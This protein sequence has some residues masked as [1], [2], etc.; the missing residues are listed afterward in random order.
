MSS[1]A[2]SSLTTETTQTHTDR[3]TLTEEDICEDCNDSRGTLYYCIP[4]SRTLCERCWNNTPPHGETS[5][6]RF[7][8]FTAVKHEK[9]ELAVLKAVQPAFFLPSDEATLQSMLDEDEQAAWFGKYSSGVDIREE[10]RLKKAPSF[11]RP[12]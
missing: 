6:R 5:R 7:L 12:P 8:Q 11:R 1:S 2:R 4:C 3:E 10:H 9:T